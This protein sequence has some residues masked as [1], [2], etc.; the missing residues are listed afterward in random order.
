MTEEKGLSL[1]SPEQLAAWRERFANYR[2]A[3]DQAKLLEWLGQFEPEHL[4]IAHRVLDAVM[5][6]SEEE[7]HRGYKEALEGL[8]GWS[9]DEKSREGR[10]YFVGA[11]GAGESGPAMLRMFREAN[12]MTQQKY[13]DFFR[14]IR[15]LPRLRLTAYDKI[16]LVDDFAGTGKQLT[17]YWPL[18]Q[19]LVASEA[20]CI[21][22]LTAM[23]DQARINLKKNTEFDLVAKTLLGEDKDLWSPCCHTFDLAELTILEQYGSK[24]WRSNPRGFGSCG[25]TFVL[26][27]KTPNNT[28]P[29]LHANHDAWT[30]PFPRNL[31]KA[32]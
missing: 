28:I 20:K 17:D 19:E 16:V 21:L 9:K 27:H 32:A 22:I 14:E 6:V 24:A 5:I 3:P 4:S 2:Q 1:A 23:T 25:L 8:R 15:E 12:N 13:Q 10:W 7:I 18:F 11:G 30:S 29:I 31:L 26:S